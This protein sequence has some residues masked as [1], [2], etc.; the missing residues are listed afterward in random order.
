VR[1][2]GLA[3]VSTF[4]LL[5]SAIIAIPVVGAY[6]D[7]PMM[8]ISAS[9]VVLKLVAALLLAANQRILLGGRFGEQ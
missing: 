1:V 8:L 7:L 9:D 3:R 6:T 2:R 4:T 5:L